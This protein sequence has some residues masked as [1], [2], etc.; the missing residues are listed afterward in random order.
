VFSGLAMIATG[1]FVPGTPAADPSVSP[2][3]FDLSAARQ[4][5][6]DAGWSD[7]DGDGIVDKQLRPTD[8]KRTPFEFTLLIYGSSIEYSAFA[9]IY[10]EDLLKI[11][12]KMRIEAVEWSLM[13]KRMDEKKFDAFTGAWSLT[14]DPD[15]Y[16]I[17]HSSQADVPK[18]SNRV[19]FRNAR[20]DAIVERLRV[21]F[22]QPERTRLAHEFH[23]LL[24]EEQPYTFFMAIQD[25]HCWRARVHGVAFAK[26]R[27]IVDTT[28]WWS[29]PK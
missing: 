3:P 4:K 5:L 9:N 8:S 29:T 25:N 27:P 26:A 13:Q 2:W 12:V 15:L 6:A 21:E 14:W 17:W 23:R 28:S 11:G 1:P 18:G 19:G 7:T 20:G 16:Q 22:D 24:H 10:R